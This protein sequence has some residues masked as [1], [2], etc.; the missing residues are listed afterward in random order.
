MLLSTVKNAIK[1]LIKHK[2]NAWVE[3][4]RMKANR[5][6][7]A[8]Q[9]NTKSISWHKSE[10]SEKYSLLVYESTHTERVY[11]SFKYYEIENENMYA[12]KRGESTTA[13]RLGIA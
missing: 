6:V 12:L 13:L 4:S 10:A 1:F 9:I 11:I 8:Q 5:V 3:K 7:A 2:S